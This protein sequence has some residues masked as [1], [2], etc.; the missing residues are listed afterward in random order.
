MYTRFHAV[1]L[2]SILLLMVFILTTGQALERLQHFEE[3][4]F[5]LGKATLKAVANEIETLIHTLQDRIHLFAEEHQSEIRALAANADDEAA[6]E[7][8][9]K[10]LGRRFP[11]FFAF[12]ITDRRGQPLLEDIESLV[13]AICEQDLRHYAQLVVSRGAA[14]HNSPWLHPQP[15]NY[16]F[17]IMASWKGDYRGGVDDG[18]FFVSFHPDL[19]SGILRKHRLT[20]DTLIL[21]KDDD[22]TLIEVTTA[23]ARDRLQR[24]IR[25][26]A[27]ETARTSLSRQVAGTGWRLLL[28]ADEGVM[29]TYRGQVWRDAALLMGLA[30]LLI[31][32]VL[33]G[34]AY[35]HRQRERT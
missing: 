26:N 27:T 4:R 20:D 30:L 15:G 18:V 21:V 28:L 6:K 34:S 16:H 5:V 35:L 9:G 8:L 32:A 23:G 1:L 19:L 29:E 14:Y 12:T 3:T 2:V 33:G 7:R 11:H 24:D 31:L 10:A 17:D 22:P 13:G 25:L